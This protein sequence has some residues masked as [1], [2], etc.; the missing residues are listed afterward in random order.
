MNTFPSQASHPVLDQIEPLFVYKESRASNKFSHSWNLEKPRIKIHASALRAM[1]VANTRIQE[2]TLT[3]TEQ[4]S[5][6]HLR[7]IGQI[8]IAEILRRKFVSFVTA[9]GVLLRV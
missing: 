9:G 8:Q 3:R 7:K 1:S 4:G 5:T 2:L 6:E